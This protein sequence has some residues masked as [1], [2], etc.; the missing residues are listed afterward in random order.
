MYAAV[1]T[2]FAVF[3]HHAQCFEAGGKAPRQFARHVA[4]VD[5]GAV[6]KRIREDAEFVA[7]EGKLAIGAANTGSGEGGWA[8]AEGDDV[9]VVGERPIE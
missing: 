8:V 3:H 7:F 2:G 4:D 9:F 5:V 6:V 1:N